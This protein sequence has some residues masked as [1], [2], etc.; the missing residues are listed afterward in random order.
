[1][2]LNLENGLL[3]NA[4]G[5]VEQDATDIKIEQEQGGYVSPFFELTPADQK[6]KEDYVTGRFVPNIFNP[7]KHILNRVVY[8][9]KGKNGFA[10]NYTSSLSH[11]DKS[12]PFYNAFFS[13]DQEDKQ[14]VAIIKSLLKYKKQAI[15]AFQ[16][17]KAPNHPEVEGKIVFIRL[18]KKLIDATIKPMIEGARGKAGENIFDFFEGREFTYAAKL[19]NITALNERGEEEKQQVRSTLTSCFEINKVP[20][21]I[22]N[23]AL[24]KPTA[25]PGTDEYKTQLRSEI[26]KVVKYFEEHPELNIMDKFDYKP[27]TAEEQKDIDERI[28]YIL[29]VVNGN[30][31]VPSTENT[32][33]APVSM[34]V[35]KTSDV[36]NFADEVTKSFLN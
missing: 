23:E 9:V 35:P 24:V 31:Q 7:T 33:Q 8:G 29:G 27:Y 36:D 20:L 32:Q 16:I 3:A 4:M 17:F 11:G 18:D 34:D 15:T 30:I 14:K 25:I 5:I 21:Y 26:L 6:D 28:T 13:I 10:K 22:N 1:M 19:E 12:C 2:D